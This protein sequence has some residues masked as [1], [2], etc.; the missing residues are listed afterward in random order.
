MG[1]HER[2]ERFE[3]LQHGA[4]ALGRLKPA[5]VRCLVLKAQGFTYKEIC[6]KTGFSYTKVDRCLKEGRSAFAARLAGIEAGD[7]CARV[8]P[9][10][11]ALVDG[12]ATAEQI[13]S[14]RP[15]LRTCLACRAR[16]VEYR[17][18]PARVAALVPVAAFAA[19]GGW[20][21]ARR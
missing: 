18:A 8:A 21:P 1:T 5:E 4:Q 20:R 15:H 16:L 12:E 14:V 11:S 10:L 7:E 3:Q 9:V 6:E 17:D 2:V 19:G 13:A